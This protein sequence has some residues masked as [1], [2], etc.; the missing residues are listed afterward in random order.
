MFG[1][2]IIF[3]EAEYLS[4]GNGD[5]RK[6]YANIP[7]AGMIKVAFVSARATNITAAGKIDFFLEHSL[8]GLGWEEVETLQTLASGASTF[9]IQ[10]TTKE[11]STIARIR[12]EV[13]DTT[14]PGQTVA[15]NLEVRVA[16]KPF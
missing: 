3:K 12:M 14:T 1:P 11:F 2:A 5:I 7:F 9:K 10:A 4:L 16:G 6:Y 8:D 15:E 13:S